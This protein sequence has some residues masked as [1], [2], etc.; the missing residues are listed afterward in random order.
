MFLFVFEVHKL[1]QCRGLV[2]TK[3]AM[4]APTDQLP[5]VLILGGK[6]LDGI[7]LRLDRSQHNV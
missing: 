4:A 3:Q 7:L 1:L 6:E 2:A 5:T